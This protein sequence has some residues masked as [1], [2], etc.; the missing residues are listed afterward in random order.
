MPT[1][2][3]GIGSNLG[4]RQAH[5]REAIERMEQAGCTILKASALLETEPWGLS[6][7][8][9]FLN[10]AVM[11]G[12]DRSP[13]DLLALLLGIESV[14]GRYRKDRWGPRCIDLDIL[15]YD[16]VAMQ[17]PELTIPHPYLH[18]RAFALIPL[19]EIAPDL[20]HPV[21]KKTIASLL[22]ELSA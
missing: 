13:H 15:L 11:I 7:Q 14:M 5:C 10:A 9:L 16:D 21:L 20:I 19:A 6:N 8:P 3:I 4:D 18:E 17:S 22:R 1:A 12:T 2:C